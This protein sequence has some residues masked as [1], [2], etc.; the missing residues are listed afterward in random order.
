[1]NLLS[2]FVRELAR[3]LRERISLL[4]MAITTAGAIWFCVNSGGKTASDAFVLEPAKNSALFGALIFTLLTLLQFHRDYKNKTDSIV[5]SCTD[6]IL[7]QVHR[8]LG[9][10]FLAVTTAIVVTLFALPFAMVKT[11]AYFQFNDFLA[12]WFLIFQAAL[13]LSILLAAGL[14]ML[15]RRVEIAFVVMAGLIILSKLLESQFESNPSYLFFWVQTNAH[16]FSDLVSNLFQIDLILWNRL[17]CL[18]LALSVWASGLCSLRRYGQGLIGSIVSNSRRVWI[19]TTGIAAMI[20]ACLSYVHE[21]TFDKSVPLDLN[22]AFDSGTGIV[23]NTRGGGEEKKSSLLLERKTVELDV[24]TKRRRVSGK[25]TFEFLNETDQVEDL[26]LEINPGYSISNVRVNGRDAHI[27]RDNI[28]QRN[29]ATWHVD[30]PAEKIVVVEFQYGGKLKN[31]G[32]VSQRVTFGICDGYIWIPSTG[33]SPQSDA[34]VS[35][36]CEFSGT[37]AMNEQ[38]SPIFSKVQAKRLDTNEG[39]TTWGFSSIGGRSTSV[40]AAD[41]LTVSFEAG[42]LQVDFKYFAK[43]DDE[44]A[45]MDAIQVMK[46]AIDYFTEAYGPLPY[47]H[48]LVMLE[49]PASFSGGF[50]SGNM[51]AMDETSFAEARYLPNSVVATPDSGSG[52]ETIVH[53]IAHQWWGLATYPVPDQTSYWSAEGITCYSTY[54]FMEHHFGTEYAKE[55]YLDVWQ[56]SRETYERAFYVQHPEYLQ[57]LSASDA[58]RVMASLRSMG[59]YDLMPLKLLKAEQAVGGPKEFRKKLAE[60]YQSRIGNMISYQDFLSATGLTTEVLDN[61]Q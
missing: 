4:A 15:F 43:H 24:D 8:T 45:N 42:G 53:E 49:L 18:F 36:D 5:L 39:K 38:L 61:A 56:K 32:A 6:P 50:A 58:S 41:Y 22:A 55:R 12:S 11:G 10:L 26:A 51:S 37:L 21:P 13:I 16:G 30:I 20:L 7:H 28:E 60:L 54:R 3:L 46:A 33:F 27:A 9:L 52:L 31:S 44:I 14:Y 35:D 25:A 48:H 1:V 29:R 47:K 19:P 59:L 2:I 34:R 57:K 17:F 23:V 40:S